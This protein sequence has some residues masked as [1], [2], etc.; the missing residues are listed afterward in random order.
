M[1]RKTVCALALM[2]C[3]L[4]PTTPSP[5]EAATAETMSATPVGIWSNPH[6]TVHVKTG[7]CGSDLCGWIIWAGPTAQADARSSGV[8]NLI[9]TELLR[10]YHAIGRAEWRGEVFVP[11]RGE[12]YYSRI[13]QID[14]A[15]L[16]I[17]GCIMG[18]LLCKS[19]VWQRV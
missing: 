1:N 10:N 2:A 19:Q 4:F 15:H 6:G 17:S 7:A 8:S 12:S 16:K 11:D 9:G 18:G 5:L 13:V 14:R 3:A